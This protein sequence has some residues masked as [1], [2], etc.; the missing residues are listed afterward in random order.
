ML[1]SIQEPLTYDEFWGF[2]GGMSILSKGIPISWTGKYD[3]GNPPLYYYVLALFFKL[4]GASD[5]VARIPGI[6]G[7]IG[8]GLLLYSIGRMTTEDRDKGRM[9]GSLASLFYLLNPATIQGALIVDIDCAMLPV[10]SVALIICFLWAVRCNDNKRWIWLGLLLSASLWA[11]L[12]TPLLLFVIIVL[13]TFLDRG[14]RPRINKT[15]IITIF[16]IGGF[17][18][19]WGLYTAIKNVPFWYPFDYLIASFVSKQLQGSAWDRLIMACRSFMQ[20]ALWWSPF[21]LLMSLLGGFERIKRF[22]ERPRLIFLDVPIFFVF[23]GVIGYILVGGITFAFP[24]YHAPF[25]PIL[26]LLIAW[27]FVHIAGIL[28]K[29]ELLLLGLLMAAGVVWSLFM[30]GDTLL[31]LNFT[32]RD[33]MIHDSGN[34]QNIIRSFSKQIVM[35]CL[36]AVA[37]IIAI[38]FLYKNSHLYRNCVLGLTAALLSS[39]LTMDITQAKADYLTRFCYGDRET[40]RM[41]SLLKSK[42]SPNDLVLATKDI[43]YYTN[44]GA[45]YWEDRV[46]NSSI[47]FSETIK[48]QD[49]RYVVYSVGH[50]TISQYRNTFLNP[51]VIAILKGNY[52]KSQ[53]GTYTVWTKNEDILNE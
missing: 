1:F 36:L 21:L 26:S 11:K 42:M 39:W 28:S 23:T 33:I 12:T 10:L 44:G 51:D 6:I 46:W 20:L 41:I 9:I 4:L 47:K 45:P 17:L 53:I 25:L 34:T 32:V 15:L 22:F 13:Y 8:T 2:Q 29:K 19:S 37:A 27:Y 49:V 14:M 48:R 7:T 52:S 18:F 24:K 16:G 35:S 5:V 38:C 3:L 40:R 43:V 50:H 30:V 31:T